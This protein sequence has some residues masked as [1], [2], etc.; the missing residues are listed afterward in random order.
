MRAIQDQSLFM[1]QM[2]ID[3]RFLISNKRM[4]WPHVSLLSLYS[5][6]SL[7]EQLFSKYSFGCF[8][9]KMLMMMRDWIFTAGWGIVVIHPWLE[10]VQRRSQRCRVTRNVAR[11]EGIYLRSTKKV[12]SSTTQR[13][14]F[15]LL[16]VPPSAAT[17][18][19][20]FRST[21]KYNTTKWGKIV[22]FKILISSTGFT[23]VTREVTSWQRRMWSSWLPTPTTP[24]R[25][26][27][28]G[29]GQCHG[30]YSSLQPDPW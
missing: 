8:L 11:E 13:K 28:N 1:F 26:S 15:S 2:G 4:A 14:V 25:R 19:T 21:T 30:H 3:W 22:N 5:F 29:S 20:H 6:K 18:G 9:T 27:G 7:Y 10:F 16:E 17:E 24:R 23:R 12:P